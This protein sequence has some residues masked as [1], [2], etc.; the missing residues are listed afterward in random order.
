M[1]ARRYLVQNVA[2]AEIGPDSAVRLVDDL[3]GEVLPVQVAQLAL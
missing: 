3:A 2:R 1:P